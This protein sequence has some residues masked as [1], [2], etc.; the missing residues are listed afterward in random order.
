MLNKQTKIIIIALIFGFSAFVGFF[1]YAN[2]AEAMTCD[3][4]TITGYVSTYGNETRA[5]FTY[6]TNW[7]TVASGGGIATPVKIFQNDGSAEQF[8][9]GLSGDTTYYYRI[10]VTNNYGTD[11]GDIESFKTPLCGNPVVI[12]NPTAS[13]SSSP[14]TCTAPCTINLNWSSSNVATIVKIYKNGNFWTNQ[15]GNQAGSESDWNV[16]VGSHR[17]CIRAVDGNWTESGDLA[18]TN[19]ITVSAAAQLCTDPNASN[20]NQTGACTYPSQL[21]KDTNAT[22]YNGALPCTYPSQLCKDT[23]ATNYNG[24]LPC[25]YRPASSTSSLTINYSTSG[26]F[27]VGD[28]WTLRANTTPALAY[29]TVEVCTRSPYPNS[30]CENRGSTDAYGSWSLSSTF[31]SSTIGTWREYVKI[32]GNTISNDINFTVSAS[33]SQIC[34]DTTASNYGGSLPCTY[35]PVSTCR[36]N[37]FTASPTS[38]TSGQSSTLTW[39]TT[40]CTSVSIT[41]LPWYSFPGVSGNA[42][43]SPTNTTNYILTASGTNGSPTQSVTVSVNTPPALC[44]DTTATNYGGALPCTYAQRC[45]DSNAT[46]YNQIG[47]CTYAQRCTDSNA[48]NYN[49]IGSCTY[50]PAQCRINSFTASPTSITAGASSNLSW[51]TTNCNS[52]SITNLPWYSF[53]GVSGNA[54]VSPTNTTNY[55]LTASGTNGSPTQ[56]VTVSVNT[57]AICQDTSASNYLGALP[58]TYAQRCTDSNATNYNQIGS[59]TYPQVTTGTLTASPMFCLIP[60]GSSNCSISLS[61]STISPVGVS[62]VTRSGGLTVATSNSGTTSVAIPFG[63]ATY[64]LYN[65]TRLLDQKTISSSCTSGTSWNGNSCAAPIINNCAISSFTAS[66]TS[67]TSGQ[68]SSLSWNTTNCN[69]VSISNLPWYSFPGVSGNANVSPTNTTNYILTASGTNGSPTQSVTVSVNTPP[70]LCQDTTATNYG[71]ALPCTYA[72]RCTDSNATNYNQIGSCTYAQRCTDSNATNYNQ[73]GSCTYAPAQCRINSFTASP[74]SITA[75]ASSNLSWSTT[76]CNSV[77]ITN[78]PWY[79]FPSVDGSKTVSPTNTTNYI[80]TASGTNGSPTQSVTVSVNTPP[81][82][83]QDTTATNYGGALPCTY[84][85]RCTDSNATNYNQIGSCT[86]AQRCTDSN[87]TNYNQIGSCTYAQRCTDSNATNYNQIGSCTYAQRCTDSNATNYNQIGSCTYAQRC[88]DSNATNYNQ[89][90]SCTYAP[91]QCR[92]NSFTASPTYINSE[93]SSVLYWNTNNCNNVNISNIGSV[94]NSGSQN[95]FPSYTTNYVLTAYGQNGGNQSQSVQVT[96]NPII[97]QP[98]YNACA[99]TTVATNVSQNS[100]TL[101][102]LITN[103]NGNVVNSYF[104]YGPTV[105]LGSTTPSLT[106]NGV[107]SRTISGLS[108]DTVYFFRSVANCGNGISYGKIEVFNTETIPTPITRTITRIVQGT[109]VVGTQ[110]PIM[111]KIENRYQSIGIGDTIDY[112]VT[113]K[114]IGKSTLTRPILQVVVPKG[115]TITNASAGTYSQTTN[116]LTIELQD[117]IPGAEGVVYLQARVIDIA[118]GTAQIVT[119]AILVYTNPNGAQENAIAYVLNSQ[120]GIT[121]NLGASAFFGGFYGFGLIGWLLLLILILLIILITRNYYR[122]STT[123][124]KTDALGASTTTT[125]TNH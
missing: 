42:N 10:E 48:T 66:P 110:S 53:P 54:N 21:C 27:K 99:V 40:N 15:T 122:K 47:S 121:N 58:C 36:I 83:C 13:I 97:I 125:T 59:C 50:A 3:S 25:T 35:P 74:T 85:Q 62:S 113:Y 79:Y 12:Q 86:Y 76:N 22:N 33:A 90:G 80:L 1:N 57:P 96:V 20:Y 38:I 24:A 18:C 31:P 17:Y 2:R 104:E 112:T 95:V 9:S 119:T 19:S 84:A 49:Q 108:T 82:L 60:Q 39:N 75:G 72:Q 78:L 8:L 93:A 81:A 102:G 26:S 117:L 98:V 23:N 61:W 30:T 109:T 43:V 34:V 123:I 118:S 5:R 124:R 69:S 7:N 105:N 67:I 45:T 11:F 71:G 92:I 89:I 77:S 116:T 37:S 32:D 120:K 73:I 4:A 106:T 56:S 115:I 70:A 68:S 28:A 46:N 65:S 6:S 101:N 94:N 16:G 14:Q 114:N 51:S 91:A 44:Q 88:T 87:A 29:K 63:S 41:N 100:A 111:L 55:I 103:P 52:V 107:Y 64:Y